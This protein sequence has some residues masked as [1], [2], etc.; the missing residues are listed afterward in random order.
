MKKVLIL[1]FIPILFFTISAEEI[2]FHFANPAWAETVQLE[3][4]RPEEFSR[5]YAHKGVYIVKQEEIIFNNFNF[6]STDFTLPIVSE[7]ELLKVDFLHIKKDHFND[8]MVIFTFFKDSTFRYYVFK[9]GSK[10][11]IINTVKVP[12]FDVPDDVKMKVVYPDPETGRYSIRF[13][14][15][16]FEE[17]KNY[18]AIIVLEDKKDEQPD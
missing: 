2:T 3:F 16:E 9:A 17:Q 13:S 1:L 7:S 6:R 14:S 10:D 18:I 12:R 15:S 8:Y 4:R 5:Y 11:V